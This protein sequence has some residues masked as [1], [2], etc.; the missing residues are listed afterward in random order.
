VLA[1]VCCGGALTSRA[2]QICYEKRTAPEHVSTD[3]ERVTSAEVGVL[4]SELLLLEESVQGWRVLLAQAAAAAPVGVLQLQ[5]AEVSV[6]ESELSALEESFQVLELQSREGREDGVGGEGVCGE[7]L[8][9][10]AALEE[11]FQVLA[12]QS[13]AGISSDL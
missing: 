7:S 3:F 12:L 4:E 13:R 10:L 1:R 8:S 11:S 5:S 2:K 9:E 6:V